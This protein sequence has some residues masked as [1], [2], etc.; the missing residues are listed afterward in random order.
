METGSRFIVPSDGLEKPG[1]DPGSLDQE[2]VDLILV[3]LC[4]K[5]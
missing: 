2:V 3:T 1:R 4:T 5:T